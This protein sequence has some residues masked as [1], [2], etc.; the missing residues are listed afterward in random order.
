MHANSPSVDIIEDA[1]SSMYV[2]GCRMF[3][4]EWECD[5][6]PYEL[7]LKD[8]YVI[9]TRN[10][11]G[12][13]WVGHPLYVYT[14]VGLFNKRTINVLLGFVGVSSRSY[15]VEFVP[16]MI[17]DD[18]TL[19]D[20]TDYQLTLSNRMWT[21]KTRYKTYTAVVRKLRA[22][23]LCICEQLAPSTDIVTLITAKEL[24]AS[25]DYTT[26]PCLGECTTMFGN[27]FV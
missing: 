14:T 24:F 2:S 10:D 18:A 12:V 1:T 27:S 25:S 7:Q 23:D 20:Y 19:D 11:A 4:Y 26:C 8:A 17:V 22:M 9:T 3:S 13:K 6:H 15:A 16:F 5:H 21:T